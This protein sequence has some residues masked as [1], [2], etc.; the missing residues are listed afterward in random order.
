[1]PRTPNGSPRHARLTAS[2]NRERG[3]AAARLD[4]ARDVQPGELF[5]VCGQTLLRARLTR[6]TQTP[7][8]WAEDPGSGKRRDLNG[9]KTTRSGHGPPSRSCATP[10]SASKS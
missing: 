1:M 3:D 9:K 6:I 10:A 7:R 8:T 2:V 4:T 5:T